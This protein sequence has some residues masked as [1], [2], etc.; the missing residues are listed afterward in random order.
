VK[1]NAGN[2][3]DKGYVS[4][5]LSRGEKMKSDAVAKEHAILEAVAAKM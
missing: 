4:G 5:I 1:I 2:L 3:D